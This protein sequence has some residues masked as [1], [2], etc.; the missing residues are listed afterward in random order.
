MIARSESSVRARTSSGLAAGCAAPI[1]ASSLASSAGHRPSMAD[2]QSG[3]GSATGAGVHG[4]GAA[5]LDHVVDLVAQLREEGAPGG[6]DR[7][8]VG[9]P[10]GVQ[11]FDETGV[12]AVKEGSLGQNLVQ[13]S[14]V[15]RHCPL[16]WAARAFSEV[17]A[18]PVT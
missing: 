12:A 7:A 16:T 5:R 10:P 13:P 8:R 4:G 14:S 18:R 9:R 2:S 6:L 11:V 1:L 3:L 15:V 17:R